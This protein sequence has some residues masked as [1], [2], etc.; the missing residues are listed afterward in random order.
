MTT[1]KGGK[2]TVISTKLPT[3]NPAPKYRTTGKVVKVK[4][5]KRWNSPDLMTGK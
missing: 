1:K 3:N 2:R 5:N 4:N